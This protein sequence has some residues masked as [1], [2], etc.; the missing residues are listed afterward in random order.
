MKQTDT[1]NEE[2]KTLSPLLWGL[3]KAPLYSVPPFYFDQLSKAIMLCIEQAHEDATT[4]SID[5]AAPPAGYFDNLSTIILNKIKDVQ[6]QSAAQELATLSP[7]LQQLQSINVYQVPEGYFEAATA[8]ILPDKPTKLVSM[9]TGNKI[10]RYAAAAV[11]IGAMVL[12]VYQ[13]LH[14]PSRISEAIRFAQLDPAIKK[15]SSMNDQ[16]F[17]KALTQLSQADISDYLE[18]NSGEEILSNSND[19]LN[20]INLPQKD[21]Y[22]LNEKTLDNYLKSINLQ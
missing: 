12:G 9:F 22:L 11:F 18:K 7:L 5:Q 19:N 6:Q 10:I 17:G 15:G 1:I 14:Q 16:Q 13:Y 4:Y 8:P 2:L 3:S 21:D 20:E